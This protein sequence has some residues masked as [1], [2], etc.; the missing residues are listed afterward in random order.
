MILSG[1]LVLLLGAL[2]VV[3]LRHKALKVTDLLLC[4]AFGFLLADTGAAALIRSLL[5]WLAKSFAAVHP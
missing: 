4:G 1:S 5:G 2:I 3:L